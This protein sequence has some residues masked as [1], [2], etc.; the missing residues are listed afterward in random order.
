MSHAPSYP[1]VHRALKIASAKRRDALQESLGIHTLREML[2]RAYGERLA[3]RYERYVTPE[4]VTP[5][6]TLVINREIALV[7]LPGEPFV[8]LQLMLKQRSP[9]AATFL[10][11]YTNGYYGYFPTISASVSVVT[12]ADTVV[13][14]VEVGAGERMIDRGLIPITACRKTQDQT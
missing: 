4:F 10:C 7:G 6:T 9:L 5:V 2:K 8:G 12:G 13:T 3:R 14:R 1:H 11:G